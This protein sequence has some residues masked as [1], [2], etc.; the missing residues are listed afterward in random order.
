MLKI[1]LVASFYFLILLKPEAQDYK[2]S[3]Y[4]IAYDAIISDS[5]IV[6]SY[7][8][9]EVQLGVSVFTHLNYFSIKRFQDLLISIGERNIDRLEKIDRL[10]RKKSS[11][12]NYG[13]IILL[14]RK[15]NAKECAIICFDKM[16]ENYLLA[17]ITFFSEGDIWRDIVSEKRSHFVLFDFCS[18]S[19]KYYLLPVIR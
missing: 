9:S 7:C 2:K 5:T 6:R 16:K 13:D 1:I 8:T 15:G 17:E 11:K 12:P 18:D 19:L 3:R 14:S 10:Q 4:Q